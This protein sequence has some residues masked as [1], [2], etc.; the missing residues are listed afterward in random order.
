MDTHSQS[1]Q[2]N[3]ST[4][5]ARDGSPPAAP[6]GSSVEIFSVGALELGAWSV[7]VQKSG[8]KHEGSDNEVRKTKSKNLASR[9]VGTS[10]VS[11][12]SFVLT[13]WSGRQKPLTV[14]TRTKAGCDCLTVS[15]DGK[16]L[17]DYFET[18]VTATCALSEWRLPHVVTFPL[19]AADEADNHKFKATPGVKQQRRKEPTSQTSEGGGPWSVV[20]GRRSDPF[21]WRAVNQIDQIGRCF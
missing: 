15:Q 14:T 19:L 13:V 9:E 12:V 2:E 10:F 21:L 11:F 1:Y 5:V 7:G 20:C 3:R 16:T 6:A 18:L 4:T 8:R 17:E